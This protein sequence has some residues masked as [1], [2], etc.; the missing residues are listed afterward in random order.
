LVERPYKPIEMP[1][2]DSSLTFV[3]APGE[4]RDRGADIFIESGDHPEAVGKGLDAIAESTPFKLKMISNRGT[5]VYPVAAAAF[6][7]VDHHRCRFVLRD[8]S[9][10]MSHA[11]LVEFLDVVAQTYRWIHV[12]LLPEFDGAAG[13]S[14]AQG[15][16]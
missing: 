8:E 11:Q 5:Q 1:R 14:K 15:E 16:D 10:S 7:G 3:P 9:A 2:V 6:D 13:Y 12:E 4:R